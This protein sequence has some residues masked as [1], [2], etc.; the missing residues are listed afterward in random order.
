VSAIAP[1]LLASHA[2][3][4]EVGVLALS[5]SCPLWPGTALARDG[6][7]GRMRN[8][9]L[10]MISLTPNHLYVVRCLKKCRIDCD[11]TIGL[12]ALHISILFA[13][14]LVIG[15][16]ITTGILVLHENGKNGIQVH[17]FF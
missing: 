2:D 15:I 11:V 4:E 12:L 7:A 3:R 6:Q 16:V 10:F 9:R 17:R 5:A 8:L 13:F 14:F 1:P